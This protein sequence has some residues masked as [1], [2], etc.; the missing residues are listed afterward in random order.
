MVFGT[1]S[2]RA[3]VAHG[4]AT[5]TFEESYQEST[6]ILNRSGA[7]LGETTFTND[8]IDNYVNDYIDNFVNDYI[9]NFVKDK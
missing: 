7:L 6:E 5:K 3:L 4:A 8:Y 2:A 9:D 1:D